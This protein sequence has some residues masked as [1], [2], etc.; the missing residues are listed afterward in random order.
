MLKYDKLK[1]ETEE[2][3]ENY[4]SFSYIKSRIKELEAEID[5]EDSIYSEGSCRFRI[6]ELKNLIK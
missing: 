6:N 2:G 1:I 3:S 5:N 4:I